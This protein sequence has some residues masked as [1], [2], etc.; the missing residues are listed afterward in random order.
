MRIVGRG[1]QFHRESGACRRCGVAINTPAA[2]LN[3]A[4]A[5]IEPIPKSRPFPNVYAA[6]KRDLK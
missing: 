5:Q 1:H 2:E 4:K 3:C 6:S